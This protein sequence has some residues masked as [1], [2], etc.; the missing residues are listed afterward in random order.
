V[1]TAFKSNTSIV[2]VDFTF[3]TNVKSMTGDT[4]QGCT[5]LEFVNM[6][7]NLTST[8][9]VFQ[10]I[11]KLKKVTFHEGYKTT[12][13]CL[14]EFVGGN[15]VLDLP[16]TLTSMNGTTF[17]SSPIPK[18]TFVLRGNVGTFDPIKN[19]G[20]VTKIYVPDAYLSNYQTYLSGNGNLSKLAPLSQYAE[21]PWD[22]V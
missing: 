13:Y 17:R 5:N 8:G 22:E 18:V 15:L 20:L 11:S 2:K 6:P 12:T 7:P 10:S 21:K 3:F 1:G 9:E 19:T 4:F 16:S 14:F